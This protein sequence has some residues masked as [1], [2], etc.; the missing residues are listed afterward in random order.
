MD[1]ANSSAGC[2]RFGFWFWHALGCQR[3]SYNGP[4]TGAAGYELAAIGNHDLEHGLEEL[5]ELS[6]GNYLFVAA[7]LIFDEP[8]S[9][10][11]AWIV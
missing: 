7:N 6:E 5:T 1:R 8:R 4:V 9:Q 11:V 2:W 3:G 10:M